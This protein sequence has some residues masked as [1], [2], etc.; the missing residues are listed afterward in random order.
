MSVKKLKGNSKS[1]RLLVHTF[2]FRQFRMEKFG[3]V[4]HISKNMAQLSGYNISEKNSYIK[5]KYFKRYTYSTN[6]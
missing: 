3:I 4:I 2:Q 6:D 1:G 5:K